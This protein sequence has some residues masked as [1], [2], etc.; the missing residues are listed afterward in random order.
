MRSS[1]LLNL[2]ITRLLFGWDAA[3]AAGPYPPRGCLMQVEKDEK[4]SRSKR[5]D[6]MTPGTLPAYSEDISSGSSDGRGPTAHEQVP[7]AES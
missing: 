5:G 3:K 7:A 4:S 1:E 2:L 6:V